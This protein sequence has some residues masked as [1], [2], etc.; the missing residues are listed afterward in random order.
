MCP[1]ERYMSGIKKQRDIIRRCRSFGVSLSFKMSSA[2]STVC[3][4]FSLP[5]FDAPYPAFSTAETIISAEAVPSTPIEFVSKL[6][7]QLVT[8]GTADTAFST[9]E[10]QAAQLI[11]VILYCSI[12]SHLVCCKS[13]VQLFH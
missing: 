2:S 13:I 6:T 1:I 7:E 11:P 5:F 3:F 12:F 4:P 9:L 10:L 8:P